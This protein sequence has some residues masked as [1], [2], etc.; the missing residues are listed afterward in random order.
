MLTQSHTQIKRWSKIVGV[1]MVKNGWGQ[2]GDTT[3]NLTVSEKWKWTDFLHVFVADGNKLIFCMLTQI[4][5][6]FNVDQKFFCVDRVK[7]W[8]GQ[9]GD[10]TQKLAISQK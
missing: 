10:G 2:S 9:S 7:N 8:C 3:L 4:H 5:K 1:S 6:N